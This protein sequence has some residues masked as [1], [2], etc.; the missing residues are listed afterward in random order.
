M[1]T[2]TPAGALGRSQ[3][4]PLLPHQ[5]PPGRDVLCC[6]AIKW[7]LATHPCCCSWHDSTPLPCI[8]AYWVHI[9]TAVIC[10][11]HLC[12]FI[13]SLSL[14]PPLPP[15]PSPHTHYL[16]YLLAAGPSVVY[17]LVVAALISLK[18]PTSQAR[19]VRL[20]EAPSKRPLLEDPAGLLFIYSSWFFGRSRTHPRG[21]S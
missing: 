12:L 8:L 6:A 14:P 21:V 3:V 4:V 19:A 1:A 11:K 16:D 7:P 2:A 10:N 13:S 5:L 18:F 9:G 20:L 15:N 17:N